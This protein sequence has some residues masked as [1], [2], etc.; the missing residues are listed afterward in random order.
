MTL[1][2]SASQAEVLNFYKDFMKKNNRAPSI[3]EVANALNREPSNIHYHLK[4][5]EKEGLL[6]RTGG[7]RGVRLVNKASKLIPLVG[8]VSCGEPIAILEETEDYVEV[9]SNMIRT[10]YA[11]YALRAKGDS[12]INAGIKS[13][14]VLLIRKQSAADNGDIAVVATGDPSSESATLKRVYFT[15]QALLLKPANDA[16]EP[17]FVKQGEIRGKMTGVIRQI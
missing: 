13:G 8:V 5:L 11:H 7:Y 1:S 6:V 17:Y 2:L 4:N 9:P 16:L 14:D 12:M 10:G 15:K 3:R